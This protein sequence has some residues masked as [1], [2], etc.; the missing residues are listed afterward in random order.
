MAVTKKE[1]KASL[2][3]LPV[4]RQAGR[5]SWENKG[6]FCSVRNACRGVAHI[7]NHHYNARLIFLFAI[8]AVAFGFYLGISSLEMFVLSVA[9]MIVFIAEVINTM[10]ED[11]TDLITLEFHPGVK[12]IKDV[13]AGVVLVSVFF[14]L[15]LGYCI[16]AKRIFALWG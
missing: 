7:L 10:V 3:V 4:G 9:I 2:P 15:I 5:N 6:L 14:S 16:F 13:A 11:I 8:F 12:I 1:E